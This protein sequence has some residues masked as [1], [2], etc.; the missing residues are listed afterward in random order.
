MEVV[1]PVPWPPEG[2]FSHVVVEGNSI[3]GG[4]ATDVSIE[5]WGSRP[6]VRWETARSVQTT[7]AP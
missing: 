3:Y 5:K 6:D 1:D 2:N 4:F 7:L